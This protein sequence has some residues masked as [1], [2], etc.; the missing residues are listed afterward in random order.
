[1]NK[2]IKDTVQ[3]VI[4]K[5]MAN[6]AIRENDF[7]EDGI[8]YCGKCKMPRQEWRIIGGEKFFVSKPC[9]CELKQW[10]E[11]EEAKKE[12]KRRAYIEKIKEQSGIDSRYADVDF[13]NSIVNQ[14]NEKAIKGLKAYCEQWEIM[15]EEGQ[16]LL[17]YGDVGVGKTHLAAC[18]ANEL[19]EKKMKKVVMTDFSELLDKMTAFD[20]NSKTVLINRMNEADLLIID[21]LGVARNTDFALEKVYMVV[22]ERYRSHKPIIFTTNLTLGQMKEAQDIRYKRIYDRIFEMCFPI[23]VKGISYRKREAVKRYDEMK[24]RLFGRDNGSEI[25]GQ[26]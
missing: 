12:E 5:I 19:I 16:G 14:D 8:L 26:R 17:I 6:Q 4:D 13:E 3:R 2:D 1:M 22:D 11:S 21:D 9:D 25:S 23:E 10:I 20:A 7:Y 24:E 15:W 18:V